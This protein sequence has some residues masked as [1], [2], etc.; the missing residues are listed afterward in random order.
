MKNYCHALPILGNC[1][2]CGSAVSDDLDCKG[3]PIESNEEVI[4]ESEASNVDSKE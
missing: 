3:N 1:Y 4:I 2:I